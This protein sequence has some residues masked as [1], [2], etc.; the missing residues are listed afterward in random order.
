MGSVAKERD[1]HIPI[2]LR[3]EMRGMPKNLAV[4]AVPPFLL[5]VMLAL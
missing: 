1:A 3:R 4:R 5:T 2:V